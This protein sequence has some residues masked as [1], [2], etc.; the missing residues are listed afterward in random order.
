M[1]KRC[2]VCGRRIKSGWKYC[3][4]HRNT[5]STF[6]GNYARTRREAYRINAL[7]TTIGIFA[8]IFGIS[9]LFVS[10]AGAKILG[11]VL[12]IGGGA[13]AYTS[14]KSTNNIDRNII[15]RQEK[16]KLKRED[17]RKEARREYYASEHK[18][19]Y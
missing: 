4:E 15:K 12:M 3:F 13:I 10:S 8:F 11:V 6:S 7:I 9:F 1:I 18:R 16:D 2:E 19:D 14:T 17:W 5:I